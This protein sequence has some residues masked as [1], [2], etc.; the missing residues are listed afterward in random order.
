MRGTVWGHVGHIESKDS[1]DKN[2]P[3]HESNNWEWRP[4][5]LRIWR[6][7]VNE[8][9]TSFLWNPSYNHLSSFLVPT[10][11]I[12][13]FSQHDANTAIF[14]LQRLCLLSNLQCHFLQNVKLCNRLKCQSIQILP[15][16]LFTTFSMDSMFCFFHGSLLFGFAWF[17]EDTARG[18]FLIDS[19]TKAL[20]QSNSS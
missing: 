6:T 10:I 5:H 19:S 4:V 8:Q 11:E 15:C 9:F 18:A 13:K 2:V 14:L 3:M 20:N 1:L 17:L 16:I 12:T 7:K